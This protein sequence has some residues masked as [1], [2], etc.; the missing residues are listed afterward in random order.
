MCNEDG[1]LAKFADNSGKFL[2]KCGSGQGVES[3]ERLI[4]Q[5]NFGIR[6][7]RSSNA[8][9]LPLAAGEFVREAA[10]ETLRL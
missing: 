3:S 1:G 2:L 8:E 10:C 4:K 9:T 7:Q 5:Q 6:D